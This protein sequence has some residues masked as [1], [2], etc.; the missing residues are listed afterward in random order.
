LFYFDQRVRKEGFDIEHM[1]AAAGMTALPA[2]PE[3]QPGL[4]TLG[5]EP[6]SG[7]E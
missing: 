7:N 5:V 1:M 3:V 6:G 2:S 4:E